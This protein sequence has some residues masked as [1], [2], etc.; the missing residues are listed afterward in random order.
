MEKMVQ[1]P[2]TPYILYS[3]VIKILHYGIF[4]TSKEPMLI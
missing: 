2:H 3:L 4:V 1:N